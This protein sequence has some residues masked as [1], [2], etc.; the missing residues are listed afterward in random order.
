MHACVK[1]AFTILP[2]SPA[3][4][5]PRKVP[6]NHPPFRSNLEHMEFISLSAHQARRRGQGRLA[7]LVGIANVQRH[8]VNRRSI[9]AG[10]R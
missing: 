7:V 8:Q 9:R 6:F 10:A 5:E 2:E 4:L 3:F 1:V